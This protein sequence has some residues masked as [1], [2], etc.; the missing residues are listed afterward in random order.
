M[1]P[2]GAAVVENRARNCTSLSFEWRVSSGEWRVARKGTSCPATGPSS[3]WLSSLATRHSLLATVQEPLIRFLEI[4]RRDDGKLLGV[5]VLA[6]GGVD[7]LDGQ[8]L[9]LGFEVGVE[10]H[11][12]ADEQVLGQRRG[13]HVVVGPNNLALLEVT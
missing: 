7:L 13:E 8:T 12:P 4:S 9:D 6:Q 2:C 5:D 1:K 11:G 10:L 3:S